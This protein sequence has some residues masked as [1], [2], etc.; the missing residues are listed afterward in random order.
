MLL[1]EFEDD[2]A[3]R[4]IHRYAYDSFIQPSSSNLRQRESEEKSHLAAQNHSR[5]ANENSS[6]MIRPSNNTAEVVEQ[7]SSDK[8]LFDFNQDLDEQDSARLEKAFETSNTAE[9]V[10]IRTF[11]HFVE[12]NSNNEDSLLE[13]IIDDADKMLLEGKGAADDDELLI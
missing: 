4:P 11:S 2:E 8:D 13:D 10:P 7:P 12:L 9:Y 3:T 1:E 6:I 5:A